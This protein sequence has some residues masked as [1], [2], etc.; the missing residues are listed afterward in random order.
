MQR[1]KAGLWS[2]ES[3][4]ED[5]EVRNEMMDLKVLNVNIDEAKKA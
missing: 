4:Q 5:G 3:E 1:T 2:D